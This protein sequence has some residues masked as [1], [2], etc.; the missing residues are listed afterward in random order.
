MA[1]QRAKTKDVLHKGVLI[2]RPCFMVVI[3]VERSDCDLDAIQDLLIQGLK[4]QFR[5]TEAEDFAVALV[6][7]RLE[8]LGLK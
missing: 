1:K 2:E 4:E 3:N 8:M 7:S 6:P 5:G